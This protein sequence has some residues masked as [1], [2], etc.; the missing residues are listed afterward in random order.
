MANQ[1]EV[2][3]Y[4]SGV[5]QLEL[6]DPVQG[7][8]GGLSNKPLLNLAN[9][10]NWLYT[11]LNQVMNG[12]LIPSTVAPLNSPTFT[13]S[14]KAPTPA[15]G[16]NTTLIATTAFV[17]AT[18]AGVLVKNV[19]GSANVALTAVEAGNGIIEFSGALTGNINV[20]VPSTPSKLVVLN[21]TTGAFTLTVKTAAGAGVAVSQN[22]TADLICDGA[23][24]FIAQSDFQSPALTGTPTAPTAAAGTNNTQIATTAFVASSFAPLASPALTGLPTAPTQAL[25]DNSTKLAT[26]AFLQST[27]AQSPA[28]GGTPTAPTPPQFDSSTKLATTAFVQR[29][30]GNMQ[31]VAVYSAAGTIAASDVGKAIN[32]GGT[33]F[34]L[35]LPT[36]V[37][38]GSVLEI[39]SSSTGTVTLNATSG[40]IYSGGAT[41]STY[42][43]LVNQYVRILFD[44]TNWVIVSGGG[45]SYFGGNGYQKLPSGLIIQWGLNAGT[46]SG[47]STYSFP[48]AFPRAVAVITATVAN[49]TSS[50]TARAQLVSTTQF[51]IG[52][53]N[54]TSWAADACYWIAIGW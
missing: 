25:G 26:T 40:Q 33:T 47:Y 28:F 52:N 36:G 45:A 49:I 44:G 7:G 50:N 27:L 42:A 31:G 22:K 4:D 51:S 19:A 30:L 15:L 43:V 24:V 37:P 8:A 3:N 16:D 1:P 32:T 10:T 35:N 5:Y 46:S 53:Y 29:A 14:P 48:I 34:T 2:T 18:V 23:N 20:I 39:Y 12:T 11:Y 6:T 13:G 41:T 38:A 54:G 9:R 17:Q 21:Q